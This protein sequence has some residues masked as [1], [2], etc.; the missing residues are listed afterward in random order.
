MRRHGR[1]QL[2]PVGEPDD[3]EDTGEPDDGNGPLP[4]QELAISDARETGDEH[5][6]RVPRHRRHTSD[7]RG[8]GKG[9]QIG[10]GREPESLRHL[11]D[12]RGENQ[13]HD[14]IHE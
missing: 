7:I 9:K 8:G 1:P 5:V 6:L 3:R 2:T 13:T 10:H 14:I 11:K 12:Q 4:K